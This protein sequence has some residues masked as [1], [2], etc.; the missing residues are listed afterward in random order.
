MFDIE[1]AVD[2]ATARL[3]LAINLSV[4]KHL[5]EMFPSNSRTAPPE[6]YHYDLKMW[7]EGRYMVRELDLDFNLMQ[8]E[9]ELNSPLLKRCLQN[10]GSCDPHVQLPEFNL[11]GFWKVEQG[12]KGYRGYGLYSYSF[13]LRQVTSIARKPKPG[14]VTP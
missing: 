9:E 7:T 13:V 4:R 3:E 14:K 10:I 11:D 6:V 5:E 12:R 1:E 2:D 8:L